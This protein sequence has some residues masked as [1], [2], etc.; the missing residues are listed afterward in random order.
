M[1]GP[2]TQSKRAWLIQ[3]LRDVL[4]RLSTDERNRLAASL[5]IQP[6]IHVNFVDSDG[7]GRS[8]EAN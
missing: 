7:D 3:A 5:G 2:A 6:V 8:K 1:K 4:A